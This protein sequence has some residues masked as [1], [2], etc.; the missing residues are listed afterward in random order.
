MK[1][2][3]SMLREFV[4]TDLSADAVGDLLTMAGFELEGI[5]D[6]E[7][8]AVLDIKVVSNRGDGLSVLGLSREVLAKDP[9]AKP[10]DLFVRSANRFAL[11][12]PQAPSANR[13]TI[14]SQDCSRYSCFV[15]EGVVNGESPEWL[16]RRLR[17]SGS[18]PISLLVDLTNYVML[19]QGQPLHAFDLA[20]LSGGK[21]FVRQA[22]NGERLTTLDGSEH[23]LQGNQLMICDGAGPVAAAGVMGGLSTEVSAT[24]TQCLIESAH[25]LNASVRKTRRQLNLSTDASY[26]FERSVDPELAIAAL[27]RFHELLTQCDSRATLLEVEDVY[28]SPPSRITIDLDLD[29]AKRLLGMSIEQQLAI[30]YLKALGCEVRDNGGQL[31][32]VVPT[33]RPDIVREEDLIEELGRVHGYERIPSVLPHGTTT[34][35]GVFGFEA[36][37]DRVREQALRVGL[38]Q[39]MSHSLRDLHPLDEPNVERIG[40]RNPGA[41]EMAWLR[42][43]LLPCLADA[44]HR[45]PGQRLQLF[46]I[47][48]TFRAGSERIELGVLLNGLPGRAE[49]LSAGEP[50]SF[51]DLK[52]VVESIGHGC[53]LQFDVSPCKTDLRFHPGRCAEIRVGELRCGKIGQI[54]PDVAEACD[55]PSATLIATIQL[56]PLFSTRQSEAQLKPVSRNPAVRR[57]IAVLI[58][59]AVPYGSIAESIERS[60]GEVL[61]DQWLFD[62]YTGAGIPEGKHSLGIALQLRKLG[63]NFTDEE[64]NQVR[65]RAVAAIESLGG[66]TR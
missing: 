18:R 45:N 29:R 28:P 23:L 41:P 13:V 40:P 62:V 12:A 47:G 22:R 9:T 31:Q 8:D 43:S 64:A 14:E 27:R 38:T 42:S 55:L 20:K 3:I 48:R 34:L 17:Q 37:V 1:F 4:E 11:N 39:T 52:A 21:I 53:G 46:E 44:V 60:V 7:G 2:P 33:W 59:R 26:R 6:V 35:G 16:Q 66:T 57:D 49:W 24:T 56:E 63:G 10:T 19:E 51:Y 30:G 50:A 58:D 54:H 61:E 36:F 32:V 5:E 25:F 15:Y 65:A